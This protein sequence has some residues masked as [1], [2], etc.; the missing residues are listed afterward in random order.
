MKVPTSLL[1]DVDTIEAYEGSSAFGP[2]YADPVEVRARF[3]GRRRAVRTSAGV[4]VIASAVAIV[5]PDTVVAAEARYTHDGNE[6]TV[7]DVAP[8]EGLRRPAY[9]ELILEGPR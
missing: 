6:Y 2:T 9:L 1:P 4:D 5:R 3:E 7:L 8:G